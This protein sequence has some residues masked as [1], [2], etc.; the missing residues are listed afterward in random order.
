MKKSLLKRL[1]KLEAAISKKAEGEWAALA[2]CA[3]DEEVKAG[4]DEALAAWLAVLDPNDPEHIAWLAEHKQYEIE[5]APDYIGPF[6][7]QRWNRDQGKYSA[8]ELGK[9]LFRNKPELLARCQARLA[10]KRAAQ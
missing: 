4:Y 5:H 8:E 7:C 9:A 3:T 6:D 1:T 10:T 2:E